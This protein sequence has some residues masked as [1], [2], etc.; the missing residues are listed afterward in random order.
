[1]ASLLSCAEFALAVLAVATTPVD[2]A[3]A[4]TRGGSPVRTSS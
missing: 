2:A 4:G 3:Q 1:M